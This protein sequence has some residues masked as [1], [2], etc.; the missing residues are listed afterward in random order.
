MALI[1][2]TAQNRKTITAH[3]GM[4]RNFLLFDLEGAAIGVPRLLEFEREQSLHEMQDGVAHPLDG[5]DVLI[6]AGMGAGLQ[7]KLARRGIQAF[8][9]TELDPARAVALFARGE[10]PTLAPGASESHGHHDHG[11]GQ[12]CGQCACRA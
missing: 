4:C 8:V 6:S 11:H 9:T 2:L 7:Q 12:G 1:A 5:V 10:L 3:A